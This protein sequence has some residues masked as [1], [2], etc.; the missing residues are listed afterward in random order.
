MLRVSDRSWTVAVLPLPTT[1][2][3]CGLFPSASEKTCST[4]A[5]LASPVAPATGKATLVP[6]SKSVPKVKP[7]STMLAIAMPT[8]RK[9]NANQ[10]L[11]LPMTST[12]PV[13]G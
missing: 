12:A 7:R 1:T 6:P 3:D 9:L 4:C 5:A 8:I 2:T 10:Y 11:R 13:P